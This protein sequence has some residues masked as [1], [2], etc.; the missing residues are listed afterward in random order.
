MLILFADEIDRHH[1]R[2]GGRELEAEQGLGEQQRLRR[3]AEHL[4]DVAG[5][6][7]AGSRLIGL[8]AFAALPVLRFRLVEEGAGCGDIF[9]EPLGEK[10]L[11]HD[12]EILAPSHAVGDRVEAM[13]GRRDH[14]LEILLVLV[15]GARGHLIEPGAGVA[16]IDAAEFLERA[17]EMIVPGL[18]F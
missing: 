1:A 13:P 16:R 12:V 9:G 5:L 17:E 7:L 11:A 18:A 15:G 4:V 3:A 2:I 8:A 6:H 14:E 10:L